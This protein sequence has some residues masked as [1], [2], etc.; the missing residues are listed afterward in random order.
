MSEFCLYVLALGCGIFLP[1]KFV[2]YNAEEEKAGCL[3]NNK[4]VILVS[5]L[6]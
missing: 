6:Y 5:M 2:N 1:V 3:A 4:V